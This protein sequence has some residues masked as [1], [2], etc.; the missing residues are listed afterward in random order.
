MSELTDRE[1]KELQH[2][3]KLVQ[4]YTLANL[5]LEQCSGFTYSSPLAVREL[6]KKTNSYMAFLERTI[7]RPVEKL[8]QTD[9]DLFRVLQDAYEVLS[10]ADLEDMPKIAAKYLEE[11]TK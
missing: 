7:K 5:L 8:Y 3:K 9:E 11:K 2:Y 10:L 4:I 6:K 1:Q